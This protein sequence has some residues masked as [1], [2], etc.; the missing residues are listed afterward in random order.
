[1]SLSESP[2][3]EVAAVEAP[4]PLDTTDTTTME[5]AELLEFC[6]I[7]LG[8]D[9]R[10]T[11]VDVRAR[12]RS[13]FSDYTVFMASIWQVDD[14]LS[15]MGG[16]AAGTLSAL[17]LADTWP[18]EI[19]GYCA[20]RAVCAVSA[21]CRSPYAW[22]LL[23]MGYFRTRDAQRQPK[24]VRSV[25]SWAALEPIP[26]V[27]ME[28]PLPA[29]AADDAADTGAVPT[30]ED[31]LAA[32]SVFSEAH[33]EPPAKKTAHFGPYLLIRTIGEGQFGKAKLALDS[34][35]NEEFAIKFLKKERVKTGEE[36][37]RI[38]REITTLQMLDHPYVVSLKEVVETDTY[39]GL[40][41]QYAP[42]GELF[43]YVMA[44]PNGH[45]EE[46]EG[47]K[48]FAQIISGVSYMHSLGI[49]HRDLKLEN[50]LLGPNNTVLISDLGFA[51]R[52]S[53]HMETQCGSPNY[54]APEL[55]KSGDYSG[56]SADIWS[57][58]VILY[59]MLCGY[60]PYDDDLDNVDVDNVTSLYQHICTAILTY[61]RWITPLARSLI[62]K[63]IVPDP[64]YRAKMS[65]IMGHEFSNVN[66]WHCLAILKTRTGEHPQKNPSFASSPRQSVS[67]LRPNWMWGAKVPPS[68]AQVT[69]VHRPVNAMDSTSVRTSSVSYSV[70]PSEFT[71]GTS[72][73]TLDQQRRMH[74]HQGIVDRRAL[75]SRDPIELIGDLTALFAGKLGWAVETGSGAV[76][77]SVSNFKFTVVKPQGGRL[78]E[79]LADGISSENHEEVASNP[80]VL[81]V[82]HVGNGSPTSMLATPVTTSRS[83]SFAFGSISLS[84]DSRISRIYSSFPL[85]FRTRL[86]SLMQTFVRTGSRGFDGRETAAGLELG[87]KRLEEALTFTVEVQRVEGM[88]GMYVVEFRRVRG[89]MWAF[90]RLYSDIIGILPL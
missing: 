64:K 73:L 72:V 41:L 68:K 21:A 35:T 67:A 49:V 39:I 37:R 33:A 86:R 12:L 26:G 32:T 22:D 60:L 88:L 59:A 31:A 23:A 4:E 71:S 2:D 82:E 55:V 43:H 28:D 6:A 18:R 40:V 47:R 5:T 53:D 3:E 17:A 57:C 56:Y 79:L 51:N 89:D 61:P 85:T 44:Q 76:N 46:A 70:A 36:R 48:F 1:M 34:R 38:L 7:A 58:G 83:A 9:A 52:N 8:A 62:G 11:N 13:I 50:I 69:R 80:V 20:V 16:R 90:K 87:G 19:W 81:S 63:I 10:N 75:S 84:S 25:V 42:G 24:L 66:L 30:D 27:E 74:I 15:L 14:R 77:K 54:A 45:V 78:D 29:V 65:E